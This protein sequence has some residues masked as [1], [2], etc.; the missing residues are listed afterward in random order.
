MNRLLHS[1][2]YQDGIWKRA[3]YQEDPEQL[4]P[5]LQNEHLRVLYQ[6]VNPEPPSA[7]PDTSDVVEPPKETPTDLLKDLSLLY[8]ITEKQGWYKNTKDECY[9]LRFHDSSKKQ[10]DVI[11]SAIPSS[12]L[13]SLIRQV[14]LLTFFH[15]RL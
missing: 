2:V 5:V 4:T 15:Y 14:V 11:Y 12:E 10:Y 8:K 7:T 3:F 9:F 13:D 6:L 1:S